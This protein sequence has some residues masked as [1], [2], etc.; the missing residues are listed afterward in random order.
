MPDLGNFRGPQLILTTPEKWDLLTRKWN[1]YADLRTS[2]KLVMIDEVHLLNESRRGATLEAVICRMKLMGSGIRY[3]A[4]SAT[5]LNAYDIGKWLG[6][7]TRVHQF[8]D[9]HRPIQL[10]R[11]VLGYP[12]YNTFSSFQFDAHLTYKLEGILSQF[13]SFKPSLIFCS[14]RR[15]VEMTA[16]HLLKVSKSVVQ[17]AQLMAIEN[18]THQLVEKKLSAMIQKGIGYHHAGLSLGD[19]NIIENLFRSGNLSVLVCT[20]TLAM[21]VNLPAYLVVIRSTNVENILFIIFHLLTNHCIA[22]LWMP[23]QF[24]D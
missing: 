14:T 6:P 15:G 1:D 9:L 2:L 21:G 17:G 22:D 24:S 23:R 16:Q 11:H 12:I 4:I 19:R 20:N 18:V 13:S 10:E 8:S 3:L 5:I 7:T